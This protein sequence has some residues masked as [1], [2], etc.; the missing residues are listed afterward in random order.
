[1]SEYIGV[2]SWIDVEPSVLKREALMFDRVAVPHFVQTVEFVAGKF[3]EMN[4]P[5]VPGNVFDEV[6]WLFEKGIIFEPDN[7][8]PTGSGVEMMRNNK[9]LFGA[10]EAYGASFPPALTQ[11]SDN[12][13]AVDSRYFSANLR[14][15]HNMNA[16]PILPR[17]VPSVLESGGEQS[18]ALQIVLHAMPSPS[19]STSWEQIFE[20]RTDQDSKDKLLDL[21]RWTNK[22][23][24]ENL[25]PIEIEQELEYLISQYRRHMRV[26]EIEVNQGAFETIVVTSVEIAENLAKFNW[27]KVAKTLFSLHERDVVLIKG[28]LNSPGNQLAYIHKAQKHFSNPSDT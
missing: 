11:M 19:P 3:G 2:K 26:H 9:T 28:E 7:P 23:S 20:F 15:D 14:V 13:C 17:F 4:L 21:R 18:T 1:M 24:K 12:A 27:S 16:C 6:I 25:T 22:I 5:H 10:C 8:W